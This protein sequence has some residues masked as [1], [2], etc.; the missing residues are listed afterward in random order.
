MKKGELGI[1]IA[2]PANDPL[3]VSW[4]D[5][6]LNKLKESGELEALKAK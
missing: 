1:G 5:N 4:V 6:Y 2:V 3:L